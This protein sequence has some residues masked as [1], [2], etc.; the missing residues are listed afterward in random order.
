MK[1]LRIEELS[2]A[3]NQAQN[4]ISSQMWDRA[5]DKESRLRRLMRLIGITIRDKILEYEIN[6]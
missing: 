3:R 5:K 6:H 1:T 4:Q 2:R